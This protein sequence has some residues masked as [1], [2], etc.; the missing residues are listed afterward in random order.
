MRADSSIVRLGEDLERAIDG[1][2]AAPE[3][4]RY[5]RMT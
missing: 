5:R 1:E 4:H 2:H 3:V